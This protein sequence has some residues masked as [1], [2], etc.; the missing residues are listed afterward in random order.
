MGGEAKEGLRRL[1]YF[2]IPRIPAPLERLRI[3]NSRPGFYDNPFFIDEERRRPLMLE[4]YGEWVLH[5]ERS[6]E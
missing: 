3:D 4:T 6:P 1:C 2:Q 5:R